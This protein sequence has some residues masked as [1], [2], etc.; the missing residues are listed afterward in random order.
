MMQI[1]VALHCIVGVRL[2]VKSRIAGMRYYLTCEKV[3]QG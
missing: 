1:C 3:R 2:A